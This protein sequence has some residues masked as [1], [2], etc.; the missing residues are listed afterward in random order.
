MNERQQEQQTETE[1]GMQADTEE[2]KKTMEGRGEDKMGT[3]KEI[4]KLRLGALTYAFVER[5]ECCAGPGLHGTAGCTAGLFEVQ[6]SEWLRHPLSW[7]W[8]QLN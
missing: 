7:G 2:K 5:C 6:W 4:E 8:V 3:E 1:E